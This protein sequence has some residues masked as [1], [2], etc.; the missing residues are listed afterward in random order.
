MNL[1]KKLLEL[2]ETK[3]TKDGV[4]SKLDKTEERLSEPKNGS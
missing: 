1:K 4:K 3:D 2:L